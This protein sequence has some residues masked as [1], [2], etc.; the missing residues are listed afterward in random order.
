MSVAGEGPAARAGLQKNDVII[1]F[2]GSDLTEDSLFSLI[3]KTEIGQ[4]VKVTILRGG[5]PQQVSIKI[6]EKGEG[7]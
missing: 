1:E 6:G 2:N 4:E 5:T 7:F 3:Q